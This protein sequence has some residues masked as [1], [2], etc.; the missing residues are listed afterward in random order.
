MLA[1][2]LTDDLRKF[3]QPGVHK[4]SENVGATSKFYVPE[5]WREASS[6]LTGPQILG[7]II[8]TLVALATFHP[9]F[10]YSWF[11]QWYSHWACCVKSQQNYFRRNNGIAGTCC[12]CWEKILSTDFL[13][14]PEI[15]ITLLTSCM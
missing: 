6:I 13:I 12:Y 10:V 4:F 1:E 15:A 8:Q 7:A 2:F 14:T 5:R 3:F 9:G 11:Q